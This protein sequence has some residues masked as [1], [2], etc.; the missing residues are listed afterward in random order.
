MIEP[1]LL[2]EAK[3]DRRHFF[4]L[5]ALSFLGGVLAVLQADLIA[6][7]I[8]QVFLH[9][10]YLAENKTRLAWLLL[11]MLLR[12]GHGWC[13]QQMGHDLAAGVKERL[14]RQLLQ[15]L[16]T[17]GPWAANARSAGDW[18]T[19]LQE[20]IDNLEAYFSR[21][22]PQLA[23]AVLVPLCVLLRVG[24]LDTTSTILL[25]ITA[26]LIPVFM[27][28]IGRRAEA[29]SRK[30]WKTL[31]RLGGHFFDVLQGL[32]ILKIFGRSKEQAAVIA[33]LSARFR[34][35]NLEVLRVAFL[36]ALVL[37][38]AATISTAIVAVTVG[39][40]LLFG[41]LDF[42]Q[43]LFVLLLAPE[44]YLPL[45]Q[46]GAQFH[47]GLSG[48]AAAFEIFGCLQ[49]TAGRQEEGDL[50]PELQR[51]ELEVR[52]MR[53]QYEAQ[54]GAALQGISFKLRAGES[55]ALVGDSGAGKSTLAGLLL[56][57]D[58]PESGEILVNGLPLAAIRR[59][60]WLANV[61]YVPQSPF[62][63]RASLAEN[64]ALARPT[65]S[66]AEVEEAARAAGLA[67]LAEGLHEGYDTLIGE[68]GRSLSGGEARRVAL[69]RAFLQ[70][71]GLIILDE[72]TAGLDPQ[73]E[74]RIE[75]TLQGLLQGR[76]VL[77]LAHRMN[78]V[79]RAD[80]I[81]VMEKG[82]VVEEGSHAQL[83]AAQGKYAALV[84][85]FRGA[86]WDIGN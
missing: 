58:R 44:F 25:L 24:P 55:L 63:L 28:L 7:I 67:Q 8:E 29:L 69:A 16:L 35:S 21:F 3:Q 4:F 5:A 17:F 19:L 23:T 40:R 33:R 9:E 71:A 46:L 10:H 86:A 15:R 72:A 79:A 76:S 43:A 45:R 11:I 53:Y 37:E 80:R 73:Q 42:Y 49:Q 81:L 64:I 56:A 12:S 57:F 78:T 14:R 85:A 62:L 59:Q 22:L 6:Q 65:A 36:S 82:C 39:L 51:I 68:A 26:P 54:R 61:A 74:Q 27:L 70:D 18:V 84:R 32:F 13:V 75:E 52:Q 30:Q 34:Q 47:A 60:H 77:I 48:K 1:N 20:G 66:R 2:R 41:W 83:L 50:E 31:T 38:L